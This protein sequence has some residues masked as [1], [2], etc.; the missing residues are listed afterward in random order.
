M[1]DGEIRILELSLRSLS[2]H[3]AFIVYRTG[4]DLEVAD[5]SVDSSVLRKTF[6]FIQ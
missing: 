6:L 1:E 3:L 5:L 2:V 4:R